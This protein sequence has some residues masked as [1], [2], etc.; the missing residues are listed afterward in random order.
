MKSHLLKNATQ[1]RRN[2]PLASNQI[3]I[4]CDT[5]IKEEEEEPKE[6]LAKLIQVVVH[7]V[8]M[9]KSFNKGF[10]FQWTP[11]INTGDTQV[12]YSSGG[13]IT[14]NL[15]ASVSNFFPKLNWAKSFNFARI[16]H[17]SS[18]LVEEGERG[19]IST[20]TKIPTATKNEEGETTASSFEN[21]KVLVKL[22]PEILGDSD[23]I[24]RMS[25][26]QITVTSPSS[27]GTTERNIDTKFHIKNGQSAAI[28]GLISSSLDKSYNSDPSGVKDGI[29]IVNFYKGKGYATSD[30]QF[31]V[32]LTPLIRT[33]AHEGAERIK[34]K[35]QVKK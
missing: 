24:I 13:S 32:F 27:G 18:I 12:S 35:F 10:S 9:K 26:L 5:E 14:T 2:I 19:S 25:E 20:A 21:A 30:T 7:F 28:G 34:E 17:N 3:R 22:T 23:E 16:L 33:N 11:S 15:I 31:V 29:P 4:P 1:N 8:E 6:E